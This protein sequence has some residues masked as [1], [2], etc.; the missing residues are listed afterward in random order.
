MLTHGGADPGSP[1]PRWRQALDAMA[2]LSI[3]IT[4][5]IVSW[6]VITGAGG[7][8]FRAMPGPPPGTP[9]G[10]RPPSR[11]S[12]KPPPPI[13]TKPVSLAG[14]ATRG[15]THRRRWPSSSTSD[16]QCPFCSKF[17]ADIFPRIEAANV[18]NGRVLM[19][20]RQL[21][22]ETIHPFAVKAAE[23]TECAAGEG[24]FWEMHDR[25]FANVKA[26]DGASL[27]RHAGDI[28]LNRPM[29]DKCM[30][31][32][33]RRRSALIPRGSKGPGYCPVPCA[34]PRFGVVRPTRRGRG[35]S[36]IVW[37]A[38][39]REVQGGDR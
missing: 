1:L 16:F 33:R 5:A 4:C 30:A 19:A 15:N 27:Q 32:E 10:H 7:F 38:T 31:G 25:L 22:L 18:R 24:K 3:V 35:Q 12:P 39:L 23:A 8:R 13:P 2:S 9:P 29:F 34:L 14:A 6:S 36:R 26:L 17:V 28:G 21:P 37:R 20:F 11:A